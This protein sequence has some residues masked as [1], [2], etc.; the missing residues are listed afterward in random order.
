[1][2]VEPSAY[3]RSTNKI[4]ADNGQRTAFI[5]SLLWMVLAGLSG[6]FTG[7]F[8]VWA[9]LA[10]I[11]LLSISFL[12]LWQVKRVD[13]DP[14][15]FWQHGY[16][17]A[18]LLNALVWSLLCVMVILYEGRDGTVVT[19]VMTAAGL[20]AGGITF[21]AVVPLLA[22]SFQTVIIVPICV[23]MWY[24]DKDTISPAGLLFIIYWGQM[25]LIIKQQ[26]KHHYERLSDH[27]QLEAHAKEM[28]AMS[29]RDGLTGLY[30]HDY[31]QKTY[32]KEWRRLCRRDSSLVVLLIDVDHFKTVN[33]TYG[34]L[35]GDQC[36]KQVAALLAAN[37]NRSSDLLARYGGEEFVVLLPDTELHEG[38]LV[39]EVLCEKIRSTKLKYKD[40]HVSVT[41]SIG[42]AV[43][44]PT[45][46][47]DREEFVQRA[48]DALYRA[49]NNGRDQ[50]VSA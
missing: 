13:I 4:L 47:G 14:P 7:P 35:I 37:I 46:D 49:K 1:M 39:A 26:A 9:F 29:E 33:D 30:N 31:F 5:Y 10:L 8:S 18:T 23:A 28:K 17:A 38:L 6:F 50:V 42:A 25:A 43:V 3:I 15:Q 21:M 40:K 16:V 41:V 12:R 11:V 27:I 48:D 19:W 24:I 36:L 34:H 22:Y 2:N 32:V 44:K 20:V 45:I